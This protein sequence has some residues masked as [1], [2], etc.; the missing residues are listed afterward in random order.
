MPAAM[1]RTSW[2]VSGIARSS[3][4]EEGADRRDRG[5]DAGRVHVEMRDEA[6]AIQARRQY[7]LR[8]QVVEQLRRPF[9]R[10]AHQVDEDDV[11]MRRLDLQAFDAAQA[12]GQ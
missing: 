4:L 10:R 5:V 1:K 6:Q 3:R 2:C 9:A 8:L 12:I 7:A 11:G